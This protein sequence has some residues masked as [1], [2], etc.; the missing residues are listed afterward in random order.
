MVGSKTIEEEIRM[1]KLLIILMA[2][3]MALTVTSCNML[4]GAGEDIEDVGDTVQDVA[5]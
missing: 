2:L 4:R 3:T 5:N 1:K